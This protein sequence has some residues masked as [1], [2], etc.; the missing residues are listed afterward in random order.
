M[1]VGVS[2]VQ[3]SSG[4]PFFATFAYLCG[5]DTCD[6]VVDQTEIPYYEV[7]QHW[8]GIYAFSCMYTFFHTYIAYIMY[9]PISTFS[10]P[11][12]PRFGFCRNIEQTRSA[13]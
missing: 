2:L 5:K 9:C 13:I 12:S 8:K 4:Y 6:I 3:G 11:P 1:L 10:P 7:S